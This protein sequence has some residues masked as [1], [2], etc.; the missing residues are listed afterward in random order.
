[1][2]R[3]FIQFYRPYRWLFFLDMVCV[4]IAGAIDLIFPQLLKV[5]TNTL[6]RQSPEEIMRKLLWVS[7]GLAEKS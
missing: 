4:I 1:M 7:L 2:I 3:R 5:L 6:F